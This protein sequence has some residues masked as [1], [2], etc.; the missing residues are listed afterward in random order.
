MA[1]RNVPPAFAEFLRESL[2]P[3][4]ATAL[5]RIAGGASLAH[6]PDI[7]ADDYYRH[8]GS[9]AR[10]ALALGGFRTMLAVPMRKDDTLLG[11]FTIYRQEVRPFSDKQVALLENF[12]AQAV[13]AMENARLISE[14]REALE[15]QTATAEVLQVINSSP[16]DLAPVFDAILEKA[17]TLCDASTGSLRIVDGD[18]IRAVAVRGQSGEFADRLQHGYPF[19]SAPLL[20]PLRNGAPFV[21]IADVAERGD[22]ISR[23][24]VESGNRTLLAV[25]LRK[26]DALLG[27]IVAGR[28]EVRPFSDKQ[29]ALLQNFAAQG[30]RDGKRAPHHRDARSL[31]AADRDLRGLAGH[32]LLSRRCR[33]GVRGDIGEGAQPLW[34]NPR[35]FIELR[36]RSIS[37]AGYA[38]TAG[39][40]RGDHS[41]AVS[42]PPENPDDAG[43]ARC[44]TDPGS[45]L[46]RT[47]STITLRRPDGPRR[48]RDC[49]DQNPPDGAAAQ[50]W[51]AARDHHRE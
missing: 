40:V 49:R 23:L 12:A 4:P 35:R 13:I 21:H 31:G 6:T 22:S 34:R 36:R 45:R 32:Q 5:G 9:I 7:A 51:C 46:A 37:G 43:S 20:A 47:A 30:D 17:H 27:M 10:Q 3:N 33:A 16:G 2:I 11:A 25:P 50:G 19:F 41:R 14:T 38:W 18:M 29:I 42:A 48:H 28:K 24:S 39:G 15:Q 1:L 8:G 44:G 26:D